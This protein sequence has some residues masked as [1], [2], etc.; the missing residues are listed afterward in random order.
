[1]QNVISRVFCIRGLHSLSVV[2]VVPSS[3]DLG[4]R[5]H[6]IRYHRYIQFYEEL[7]IDL[8]HELYLSVNVC[9]KSLN[10]KKRNSGWNNN[11][12]W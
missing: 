2:Q 6:L 11:K 4:N 12:K 3:S 7:S 1:M 10:S 5:S 8:R 9:I